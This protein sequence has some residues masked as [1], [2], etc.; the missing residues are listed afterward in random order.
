[1]TANIFCPRCADIV[2]ATV[3]TVAVDGGRNY[4][5]WLCGRCLLPIRAVEELE[6]V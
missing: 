6:A 3:V 5:A 2:R 4:S 1:M